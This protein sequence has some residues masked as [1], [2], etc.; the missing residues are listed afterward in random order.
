MAEHCSFLTQPEFGKEEIDFL[1]R[2]DD[3]TNKIQG[4]I[5]P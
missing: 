5:I 1:E 3:L 2:W 4:Y